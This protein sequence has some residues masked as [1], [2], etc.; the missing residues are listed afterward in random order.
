MGD[1]CEEGYVTDDYDDGG[2]Y[3]DDDDDE[4]G[5]ENEDGRFIGDFRR[6]ECV[7]DE[8]NDTIQT[9]ISGGESDDDSD[10]DFFFLCRFKRCDVDF[11][12]QD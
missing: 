11:L 6:K 3:Y 10:L 9:E 2:D 5:F 1:A 8:L 7:A 12:F 4:D